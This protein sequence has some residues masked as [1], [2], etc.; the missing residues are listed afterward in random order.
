MQPIG[1]KVRRP[2]DGKPRTQEETDDN[3]NLAY[4]VVARVLPPARAK[5]ADRLGETTTA[6]LILLSGLYILNHDVPPTAL[7]FAVSI[8]FLHPLFEKRGAKRS[9]ATWRWWSPRISSAFAGGCD[10]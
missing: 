10:G 8:W 3:G 9:S 4:R 2:F 7:L 6:A 1:R 5:I